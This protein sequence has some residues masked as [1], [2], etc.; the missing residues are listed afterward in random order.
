MSEHAL[1]LLERI[2]G[3]LGWLAA[4]ALLHPAILLRNP[5]RRAPLSTAAATLLATV[6]GALGAAIYPSYSRLVRRALYVSSFHHGLLFERKEHL[7]FAAI[8]LS[9][10][11]CALHLTARGSVERA[12]AAHWAFVAAAVLAAIVSAFGTIIAAVR[13]F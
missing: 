2:H 4:A 3:H 9:W 12:R 7:A 11:G 5:R 8:A 13:S 10:A 1:R 6:A